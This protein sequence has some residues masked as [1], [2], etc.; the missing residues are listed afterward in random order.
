[1][2]RTCPPELNMTTFSLATASRRR[3]LAASNQVGRAA[4][5]R[6]RLASRHR[7]TVCAWLCTA[8]RCG[9]G[10]VT[11]T[12]LSV[13]QPGELVVVGWWPVSLGRRHDRQR[14]P[15]PICSPPC[16]PAVPGP[17]THRFPSPSREHHVLLARRR[18]TVPQWCRL[19]SR[20]PARG[21]R[22]CPRARQMC[23]PLDP[24]RPGH[25]AGGDAPGRAGPDDS[26]AGPVAAR[27]GSG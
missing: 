22:R 16:R 6:A 23:G 8:S 3:L 19:V 1:M 21:R 14:R 24:V 20:H 27:L 17:A 5:T 26:P 4:P 18:Q 11:K 9:G 15:P 10:A 25:P 7:R 2:I 13:V 12:Q